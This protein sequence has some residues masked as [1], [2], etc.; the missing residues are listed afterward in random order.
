MDAGWRVVEVPAGRRGAYEA[1]LRLADD[2]TQEIERYRD[3]GELLG[4]VD[5]TTGEPLGEVL[6]VPTDEA[7]TV[8][9]RSVA[10][11]HERQ[12]R[13]LG[14]ALVGAVLERLRARGVRRVVVGTA[15]SSLDALA[16]YQRQG[17]RPWRIERD[18]FTVERGYA[19]DLHEDGML[20][21]DMIWLDRALQD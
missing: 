5:A 9:L 1:L 6:V 2:S 14:R 4:M 7:G 18:R 19:P 21:R 10:V 8:E 13:G 17:F 15:S 20:V 11:V 12:G 3:Q 16:F